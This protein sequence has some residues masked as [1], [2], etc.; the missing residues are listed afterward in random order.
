MNVL[1]SGKKWFGAEVYS[2]V[3]AKVR[4]VAVSAPI[5]DRLADRATSDGV[6]LIAA[7]SLSAASMPD[8]VD[9]I[10]AAHSHDFI[11]EATRLRARW[12]GIGYHPSLLPVHRGRDAVEWAI[13]MG[14]RV[15][16]GTV[17][18]L[19]NHVD[20][21]E[22]IAQEHVFIRRGD[23]A[24]ALWERDLGPLGVSML[25]DAVLRFAREGFVPGDAQDEGLATWEPSIGRPPIRRP[26]LVLIGQ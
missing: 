26:D 4:V 7:G 20:G 25:S 6:P 8:G 23:T 18:R 14:D 10:V 12:G 5:G 11:G 22:V 21:G 15:T 16:G 13:R 2:A 1:I 24:R 3:S 19:S 17:Y 9:L